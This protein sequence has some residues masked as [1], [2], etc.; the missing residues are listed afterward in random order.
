MYDNPDPKQL[1]IYDT[2]NEIISVTFEM[3]I[4][5]LLIWLITSITLLVSTR[6]RID[7]TPI[8]ISVFGHVIGII[9][10]FSHIFEWYV[11]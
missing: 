1:L 6:S 5:A 4:I 9:I 11:D 2:Y 8:K 10:L 7:W 3:W